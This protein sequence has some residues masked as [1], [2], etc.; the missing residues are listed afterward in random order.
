MGKLHKFLSFLLNN[1]TED[2]PL[3]FRFMFTLFL[4][5]KRL[6]F[7]IRISPAGNLPSCQARLEDGSR[8]TQTSY[9]FLPVLPLPAWILFGEKFLARDIS[10]DG[11]C[12]TMLPKAIV[13][14][15]RILHVM[16]HLKCHEPIKVF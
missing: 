1:E 2:C 12:C 13:V 10:E 5:D 6:F 14:T 7:I 11:K 3:K 16:F 15:L 9:K 8:V 4:R